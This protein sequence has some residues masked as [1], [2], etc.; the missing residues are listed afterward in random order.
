MAPTHTPA[1]WLIFL[2]AL[3]IDVAAVAIFCYAIYHRRHH[4]RDVSTAYALFN[5]I[6]FVVLN[7]LI[8]LQIGI[9][10]GFG[11]FAVLAILRLRSDNIGLLNITYFFGSIALALVNAALASDLLFL[12]IANAVIILGAFIIDHPRLMPPTASVRLVLKCT[13]LSL[14]ANEAQVKRTIRE[15]LGIDC[16]ALD[17]ESIDADKQTITVRAAYRQ[18]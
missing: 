7:V 8:G 4:R 13:D 17:I 15:A 1:F 3:L 16:I 2:R 14:A 18:S 5:V 6:L 11:L 10:L 12:C 9:A